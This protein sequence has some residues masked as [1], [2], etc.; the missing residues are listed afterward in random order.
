MKKSFTIIELLI[1]IIFIMITGSIG[2]AYYNSYNE[3]INLK[4]EAKKLADVLLLARKKA[5]SSELIPTPGITPT[6]CTDFHGYRVGITSLNYTLKYRCNS[7][8]TIINTYNFPNFIT[9]TGSDYNFTFS[10]LGLNTNIT[11]NTVTLKNTSTSKCINIS[12]STNGIIQ[13]INQLY[14]CP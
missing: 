12:I 6:Y 3:E 11:L 14:S 4:S 2:I 13:V 8:D 5:E 1:I 7:Q 9:Y 10:P